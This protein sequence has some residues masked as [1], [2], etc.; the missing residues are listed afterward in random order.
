MLICRATGVSR[1]ELVS[2]IFSMICVPPK[3]DC[4]NSSAAIGSVRTIFLHCTC[5]ARS[6]M[7]RPQ[8]ILRNGQDTLNSSRSKSP[9]W[10]RFPSNVSINCVKKRINPRFAYFP[11]NLHCECLEFSR[12]EC[13]NLPCPPLTSVYFS[14]GVIRCDVSTCVAFDSVQP[15]IPP[16]PV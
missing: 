3:K 14:A 11:L 5:K 1:Q 4:T 8:A 10:R 13:E 6:T 2:R 7:A 9:R 15:T 16:R 12:A